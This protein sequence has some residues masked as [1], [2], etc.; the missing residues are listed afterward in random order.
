MPFPLVLQRR[1]SAALRHH[2]RRDIVRFLVLLACDLGAL[3]VIRWASVLLR[4][5]DVVGGEL[6]SVLSSLVP[7]GT[8]PAA[9]LL[10]S[11]FLGLLILGNYRAGDHR[12]NPRNVML[13]S[14]LGLGLIF[15]A[16]LW[17]QFSILLL[18]GFFITTFVTGLALVIERS[19]LDAIV[20]RFRLQNPRGARTLIISPSDAIGGIL[21]E[22]IFEDDSEFQVVGYL[23]IEKQEI[24]NSLGCVDD[25]INVIDAH[26]IDTVIMSG[27]IDEGLFDGIAGLVTS[28]G[29]HLFSLPLAFSQGA[30]EPSLE[31]RR[32]VPLLGLTRPGLR[33]QQLV[34]KRALDIVASASGLLVLTPLFLVVGALVKLSSPGPVFFSQVRVGLGG[35]RFRI[36]KFRS[37]VQDAEHK[38][39]GLADHNICTD[40]RLF[41][42]RDDPRTTRLGRFIRRTSIDELPQLWNVLCGDMSLVGPRPPLP[43]EVALY[44]EYQY[45]RFDMKPGVTGP[46]Q[47]SGRNKITD[48]EE[49]IR[50]E[51]VYMRNWSMWK[52]VAILARTIPVVLRMAGAH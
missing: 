33:G 27:P 22:P 31:W 23:T 37:M 28:A 52:D 18:L 38:L 29:C 14:A 45:S 47:V 30:I 1:A 46:W 15:W 8:Y 20:R 24:A 26:R 5:S 41:K 51:R 10:V 6:A 19:V 9:Q 3:M 21:R 32:G 43:T 39:A 12:R 7:R 36:H 48:F 49:V 35:K 2:V 50:L 40:P 25:L 42:I 34:M 13:G 11:L 17:A 16:R 4:E 44:E